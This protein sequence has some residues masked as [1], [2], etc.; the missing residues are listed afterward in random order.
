VKRTGSS[1]DAAERW[2]STT[3]TT[4]TARRARGEKNASSAVS[5]HPRLIGH[6]SLAVSVAAYE[7]WLDEP[8]SSLTE[9]LEQELSSLRAYLS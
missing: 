6:L 4:A 1:P 9:L 2:A 7:Q 3:A 5:G 8:E